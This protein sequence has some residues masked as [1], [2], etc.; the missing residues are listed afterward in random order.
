MYLSRICTAGVLT[1]AL[2]IGGAVAGERLE[3]HRIK[4]CT[5]IFYR[6]GVQQSGFGLKNRHE[7][8]QVTPFMV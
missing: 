6:S 8:F 5:P 3:A 7:S 1:S 2:L 4:T